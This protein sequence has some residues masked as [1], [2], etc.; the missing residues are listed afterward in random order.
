MQEKGKDSRP[1]SP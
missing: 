1:M